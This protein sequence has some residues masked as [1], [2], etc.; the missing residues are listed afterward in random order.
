MANQTTCQNFINQNL[1]DTILQ[2][3]CSSSNYI[4]I[5]DWYLVLRP[6]C[7]NFRRWRAIHFWKWNVQRFLLQTWVRDGLAGR[8][9]INISV[10]KYTQWHDF[11]AQKSETFDM[12]PLGLIF[13]IHVLDVFRGVFVCMCCV[14]CQGRPSGSYL[15]WSLFY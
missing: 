1:K 4:C 8:K 13:I 11:A 2:D 12:T 14:R 9:Y 5:T 10:S 6:I 3:N 7:V 15:Q